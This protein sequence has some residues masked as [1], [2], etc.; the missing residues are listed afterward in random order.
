MKGTSSSPNCLGLAM[1]GYVN[2]TEVLNIW[3][4][5]YTHCVGQVE[6]ALGFGSLEINEDK[7][8]KFL[9]FWFLH[10]TMFASW[11]IH[12]A[13]F[14]MIFFWQFML[15]EALLVIKFIC[16]QLFSSLS[17]NLSSLWAFQR[18]SQFRTLWPR[19]SKGNPCALVETQIKNMGVI[20][21]R[22]LKIE[23]DCYDASKGNATPNSTK[24]E[25]WLS[26]PDLSDCWLFRWESWHPKWMLSIQRFGKNID[27]KAR[28]SVKKSPTGTFL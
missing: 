20:H 25:A 22:S 1:H 2:F 7:R 4:P 24:D 17:G 26:P 5:H 8:R 23:L 16:L 21:Y 27:R 10:K 3:K 6:K 19:L 13:G 11:T 15:V 18:C 12:L 9:L 14:Y 28:L